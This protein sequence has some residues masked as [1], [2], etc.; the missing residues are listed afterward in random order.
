MTRTPI[1]AIVG[2]PNVGKSTI[3][4]RLIGK[5]HAIIL[6]TPGVTRDRLYASTEWL[7]KSF[8]LIDT[9]GIEIKNIPL[10]DEIN[11]Q[12]H[13]ALEEADV[14]VFV[15]DG[16]VGTSETDTYVAGLLH[17]I[18]K[19]V[20]LAV[21]KID[22]IIHIG[23]TSEFYSLG[24]PNIIPVSGAHGIGISDL[25]DEIIKLIPDTEEEKEDDSLTFCVIGQPNV[26]KSSLINALVKQ[27]RVIVS[28]TEGTTRDAIDIKFEKDGQLYTIIDTAGLKK[29]GRIIEKVDK[30]A[31]LRAMLAIE[32]SEV[33]LFVI[34][35]SEGIRAQDKHVAGYAVEKN[36]A[37]IIVIN[38]WDLVKSKYNSI[39]EYIEI[40]RS[41][42][43]FLDYAP[44]VV[45]S[46]LT[47]KRINTIFDKINYVAN[48]YSSRIPTNLLNTVIQDA[49]L[50]N[51]APLFNGGRLKIYYI[52]QVAVKP[53]TFVLFVNNPAFLHFSYERYIE[54]KL[55]EAFIL[56]GTPIKL[57][58]RERK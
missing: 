22:D 25:L 24:F 36:K 55:R 13:L 38:K 40:V 46:A 56:D 32:R 18:N 44:V 53:P 21:N 5:R 52:N 39:D 6:D 9:G 10:K 27:E 51:E 35:A 37:I 12:V 43:K 23:N 29:R 42:L 41:E 16:Q 17:K 15:V 34:D 47:G 11:E 8:N 58:F 26:G 20:I 28:P 7:S 1:V 2:S 48:A 4:N 57:I 50:L 30:Y 54:N 14:V 45:V 33:V 49:Q 19:P 31:A 3:F